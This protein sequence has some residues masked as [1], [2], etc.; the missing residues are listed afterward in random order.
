M[1]I[2]V[3]DCT[4]RDGGYCNNWEFGLDNINYIIDKLLEA[5]IDIIELG[6]LSDCKEPTQNN[7]IFR[8]S[9]KLKSILNTREKHSKFLCM[10]NYGEIDFDKLENKS[11]MCI[12]GIRLAFHKN[13]WKDALA[14]GKLIKEKGYELYIQ[15]MVTESYSDKELIEMVE[16]ANT[17]MPEAFYIVDS[18]GSVKRDSLLRMYYLIN[19]SL[20]PNIK[21]GFHS[22]NNMQLSYANAQS[23]VDIF[24]DREKIIDSSVFG[25]GRGAG[26]LNTELFAEYLNLSCQTHYSIKPLLQIMDNV[27][28]NIYSKH[29]W[30]YSLPH[31]LSALYN[32]HPNYATYLS[33]KN[34]LTVE[35]IDNILKRIPETEKINFNQKL[36]EDLY[37]NYQNNEY[38]D[39]SDI[40]SLE[41]S[42]QNRPV[43]IL[44]PGKSLGTFSSKIISHIES[45]NAICISVNFIPKDICVDYIFISNQKRWEQFETKAKACD[46]NFIFTSNIHA[47]AQDNRHFINY[48]SLR[49]TTP[50]V[51]DNAML[52][53]LKLLCKIGSHNIYIAG[54][55][56]YGSSNED[57][58]DS[59]MS[60]NL[61][62]EYMS[63]VNTGVKRELQTLSQNMKITWLTPSVFAK[64]TTNYV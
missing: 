54:M 55:D 8:G 44:A 4:L 18:F 30:G 34:K 15:P 52:M 22:H 21:I 64:E 38:I 14:Q 60:L 61:N 39:E 27:L 49:N 62:Q 20:N 26:N 11:S 47:A 42:I 17:I 51:E 28:D 5:N 59:S 23:F 29:Y 2:Q 12:D 57:Y 19:H 24:D 31:Y 40:I 33:S 13:N 9:D 16:Y 37:V 53:L 25:M 41:E 46:S 32:C 1:N 6:F 45:L 3:L 56:G 35:S 43:V 63:M 36:I 50:S 58:F 10:C 7:S 48:S